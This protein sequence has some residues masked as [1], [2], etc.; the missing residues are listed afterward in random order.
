MGKAK[1]F[2]FGSLLA[3]SA[4]FVA[5]QYHV[6]RS[7]DGFQLVPRTPQASL[8]LAFADIREWDANKWID[9]PELA[10]A[11]M[12]HGSSDLISQ[13]VAENLADTVATESATL[14]QL[15]SFL[16]SKSES[17]DAADS[18]LFKLPD[19]QPLK[20][21]DSNNK[22][23]DQ[24]LFTIP[25]P[26]EAKKPDAADPF[27]IAQ[28]GSSASGSADI[29]AGNRS[30]VPAETGSGG[31]SASSGGSRFSVDDVLEG[32]IGF[33][34]E[35]PPVTNTSAATRTSNSGNSKASSSTTRRL[36]DDVEDSIFGAPAGPLAGST[37]E[38]SVSAGSP[39]G[40]FNQRSPDTGVSSAS[41]FEDISAGL[42]SRARS[43][44]SR[45]ESSL[46]EQAQQT[47][48]NAASSGSQFVRDRIGE[49]IRSSSSF[50]DGLTGSSTSGLSEE[51]L[52][53]LREKFDPFVE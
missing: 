2:L 8:G 31:G 51:A 28:S 36:V 22:P 11:L 35:D 1:P 41:P 25:I 18:D 23:N 47:L 9:R 43:A 24:D 13:S 10:R 7:H 45:A 16:N 15:R 17:S 44:L 4:M 19:L 52:R 37:A 6:V 14:D 3:A 27:R 29:A 46:S 30:S 50:S 38:T 32:S 42:E 21:N 26:R 20:G 34:T 48:S 33:F 49:S 40:T 5:M 39:K 12:A 53:S